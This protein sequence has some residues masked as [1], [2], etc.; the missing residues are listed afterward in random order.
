VDSFAGPWH[1]LGEQPSF[2]FPDQELALSVC[3]RVALAAI[4]NHGEGRE[5]TCEKGARVER[6]CS[7]EDI[8]AADSAR[9]DYEDW[10]FAVRPSGTEP[11]ARLSVEARS[12]EAVS[13]RV[14]ELSALFARF[15]EE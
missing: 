6:R 12:P 8:E 9:V 1:R 15:R 7:P 3:R 10:W 2:R 11:I 5:I 4:E 14:D 13:R